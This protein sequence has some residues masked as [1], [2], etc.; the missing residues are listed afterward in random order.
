MS[1]FS[2]MN[3][4]PFPHGA[5]KHLAL[6]SLGTVFFSP[7]IFL[8]AITLPYVIE[9][10]AYFLASPNDSSNLDRAEASL[11]E[12]ISSIDPSERV[13]VLNIGSGL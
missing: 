6:R 10:R 9:A 13:S 5:M 8:S 1:P 4:Q 11:D 7:L 2:P 12:L 3:M